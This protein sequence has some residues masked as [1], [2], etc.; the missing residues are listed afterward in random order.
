MNLNRAQA[1]ELVEAVH[2]SYFPRGNVDVIVAPPFLT[3]PAVVHCL[4]NS[5]IGVA[6]QNIHFEEEGAFT[7]ECSA[8]Q[9]RDA[10]A[11]YT[12]IGHSERRLYFS[13][14][15]AVV[16]KKISAA[17]KYGLTPI[18]CIGET[19]EQRENGQ[20]EAVIETQ[21]AGGLASAQLP[22]E[23]T[24]HHSSIENAP[25]LMIAYE[26]VWAIGTG[27]TATPAQ[28]EEVHNL[29]RAWLG[30]RFG[31][32]V[33]DAIPILYGGS[34]KPSNSKEL[35]ALPNVDGALV[36]GASLNAADFISIIQSIQSA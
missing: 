17:F 5:Y 10:G 29:I 21:L 25:W 8:A 13:E 34:V 35:L 2:C 36:G 11:E 12:L 33:S 18:V 16:S 7:G 30:N 9:V 1:L 22:L 3:L 27:K 4:R 15:D 26:P 32:H 28:V 6:A 31:Q 20:V 23:D 24:A 19:L 14:S